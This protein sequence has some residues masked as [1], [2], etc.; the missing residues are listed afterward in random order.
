MSK[1]NK[2]R[3]A[4]TW[5]EMIV[6]LVLVAL[7]SLW[8]LWVI[9]PM[10]YNR[11]GDVPAY[12]CAEK[13]TATLPLTGPVVGGCGRSGIYTIYGSYTSISEVISW[14]KTFAQEKGVNSS[15]AIQQ[16]WKSYSET[17][18]KTPHYEESF[19]FEFTFDTGT[20]SKGS[21]T[22]CVTLWP[23]PVPKQTR[24]PG[25]SYNV[26]I[27]K[28]PLPERSKKGPLQ[29]N[30]SEKEKTNEWTFLYSA[31]DMEEII[32]WYESRN[33]WGAS[34]DRNK[35]INE[36]QKNGHRW[37]SCNNIF[38]SEYQQGK[39][40]VAVILEDT[41]SG[42]AIENLYLYAKT[43][44]GAPWRWVLYRPTNGRIDIEE[45]KERLI[46]RTASQT[47]GTLG[48][49]FYVQPF[50][51]LGP[52]SETCAASITAA[53][54]SVFPSESLSP[55]EIAHGVS[56]P[57]AW[58][59][60]HGEQFEYQFQGHHVLVTLEERETGPYRTII[61]IHFKF[62]I[63]HFN[64]E[65]QKEEMLDIWKLALIRPTSIP[66][67][68][69]GQDGKLIFTAKSGEFIMETSLEALN[70]GFER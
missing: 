28:S 47:D 67:Q 35:A 46:F 1:I 57:V 64:E 39:N 65:S 43:D 49:V 16:S 51:Q 34:Q 29:G 20:D 50:D 18:E 8:F 37:L 2:N 48:K 69:K 3:C 22:Y 4:F 45:T 23:R 9:R 33:I 41:G 30:I 12:Q 15:E 56:R 7:F 11:I 40:R 26:Q 53:P 36:F 68:V 25:I 19:S 6:V 38:A 14:W 52:F 13:I 59:N 55:E 32:T 10:T 62:G 70:Q 54:P 42:L 21:E 27:V 61:Y 24:F 31:K 60:G 58:K 63:A 5:I 66:V 17:A 44:E